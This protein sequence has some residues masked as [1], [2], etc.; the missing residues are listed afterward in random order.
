M[1]GRF[2]KFFERKS[3]AYDAL[4]G[5][6]SRRRGNNPRTTVALGNNPLLLL[7]YPTTPSA[8]R[9]HLKPRNFDIGVWLVIRLCLHAIMNFARLHDLVRE[10]LAERHRSDWQGAY[11]FSGRGSGLRRS[12]EIRRIYEESAVDEAAGARI[13]QR[14]DRHRQARGREGERPFPSGCSW[15]P[16]IILLAQ[17]GIRGEN[18]GDQLFLAIRRDVNTL[19]ASEEMRGANIVI[20]WNQN[21]PVPVP[22]EEPVGKFG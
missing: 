6:A 3:D 15:S 9:N 14:G 12:D 5:M 2:L 17:G 7:Q 11:G 16:R 8:R 4:L 21:D 19:K 20:A 13:P 22:V 18:L 1:L 10:R